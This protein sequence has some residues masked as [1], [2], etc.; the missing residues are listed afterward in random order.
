[1]KLIEKK[2]QNRRDFIGVYQCESCGHIEE[3]S[4]YDDRN[5]HDNVIPAKKCKNCGKSTNEL[6]MEQEHVPTR[7]PDDMVV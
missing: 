4:S 3:I 6:G 1:M 5:F 2:N 7:Y